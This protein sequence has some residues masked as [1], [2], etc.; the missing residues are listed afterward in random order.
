MSSTLEV[1][2]VDQSDTVVATALLELQRRAYEVE[3]G[4]IGSRDIPPLTE[5][6][7]ELQASSETFLAGFVEGRIV[8]AVSYRLLGDT[9]DVHRLVVDPAHFRRGIGTTL[10]RAVLAVE[11]SARQAIVQ[12]GADNDP[13]RSLYLREGFEQTDELEVAPGLRV[14]RF[15]KRLR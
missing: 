7:E 6:P 5:T 12:T 1:V 9:L 10:V 14:A 8:G 2:R 4:L 15:C 13:A 11:P 3:A